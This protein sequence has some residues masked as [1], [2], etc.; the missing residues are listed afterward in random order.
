MAGGV[1]EWCLDGLQDNFVT[2]MTKTV[3]PC[4]LPVSGA[5]RVVRGGSWYDRPWYLRCAFRSGHDPEFRYLDLGFRV[6]CR[7]FRRHIGP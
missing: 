7:G 1:W 2:M 6:V 5:P 4:H 3:N